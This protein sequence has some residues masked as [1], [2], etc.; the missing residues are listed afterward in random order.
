MKF[1]DNEGYGIPFYLNGSIV[2]WVCKSINNTYLIGTP[3]MS[4]NDFYNE[5]RYKSLH[6][7]KLAIMLW[8]GE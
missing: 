2:G 1:G 7:A 5:H 8:F 6:A 3:S 4:S